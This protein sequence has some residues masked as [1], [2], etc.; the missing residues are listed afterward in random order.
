LIREPGRRSGY[1]DPVKRRSSLA[2]TGLNYK[3]NLANLDNAFAAHIHCGFA[4]VAGPVGVTVFIGAPGGG[5]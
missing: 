2:T 4:E 5:P 3:I 1:T